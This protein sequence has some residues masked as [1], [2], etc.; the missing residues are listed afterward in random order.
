MIIRNLQN[1]NWHPLSERVT[2]EEHKK[3]FEDML[4]DIQEKIRR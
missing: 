4:K 3:R 1:M 2:G